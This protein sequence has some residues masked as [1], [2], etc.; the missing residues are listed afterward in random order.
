MRRQDQHGLSSKHV[1]GFDGD[2]NRQIEDT[3]IYNQDGTA[4]SHA[5]AL[6]TSSTDVTDPAVTAPIFTFNAPAPTP[7]RNP[8]AFQQRARES[9]AT[10]QVSSRISSN[11]DTRK[12]GFIDRLRRSR[13]DERDARGLDS[14]EKAEYW[15]E[16]RERETRLRREAISY[17]IDIDIESVDPEF[18]DEEAELSPV[19][20]EREVAELVNA[21]Y[22][23]NGPKESRLNDE[24]MSDDF[25]M[26]DEEDYAEAFLEM[27]S[28]EQSG[29][30]HIETG[31]I[32]TQ[33]GGKSG[34]GGMIARPN[35]GSDVVADGV[36]E[37]DMDIS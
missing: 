22:D 17:D 5:D 37:G 25:G 14:F 29:L 30:D 23:E 32:S 15:R 20:D 7:A 1:V 34:G 4:M 10:S 9:A 26:D 36:L 16:R 6:Y 13:H 31:A 21:F 3:K 2:E 35:P 12:A 11:R 18:E 19:D 8:F 28:Q 24:F 33:S 27:L